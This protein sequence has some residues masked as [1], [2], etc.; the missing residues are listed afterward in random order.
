MISVNAAEKIIL[1]KV[2][3]FP[4][5]SVALDECLGMVLRE[6]IYADRDQP[7]FDKSLADGIAVS[8]KAWQRG[9]K[10]FLVEGI[11]PAGKKPLKIK[12]HDG[13]VE[14]MTG[15]VVP[16]GLDA[17]VPVERISVEGKI[18]TI[19][20]GWE[21][22]RGDHIRPQGSDAGKGDLFLKK[23]TVIGPQHIGILASAG[24]YKVKV[25]RSPAIAIISTG[26]ELVDVGKSVQFYQTRKSNSHALK[27]ILTKT[28]YSNAKMFHIKDNIKQLTVQSRK[29]LK[30]FDVVIL[31]G[32]V[33]MGKFD[34]VPL[35]LKDLK[36]KVLFHR[37]AQKPG[38]PF[39][40]GKT[41]DGKPVF[42]LPGNPVSTQMCACR[43]VLPYLKKASGVSKSLHAWASLAENFAVKTDLAYFLPVRLS[44]GQEG[45]LQAHPVANY[46]GSGDYAALADA[47]GFAEFPSGVN[48]F[49]RE[50][51]IKIFLW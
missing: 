6:D 44:S 35:V 27:A 26:D 28:G 46:S 1:E 9:I 10:S 36:V 34:Y 7:P 24:K 39:W 23:G 41:T 14:I 19:A 30:D 31:S 13:C 42:A 2:K 15:A 11:Q 51:T 22:R 4:V 33:S 3:L 47:D 50:S 29:V 45:K 16:K 8:S 37:V 21:A 32:G 43:Y 5:V 38:K 20:P 48:N 40:F 49:M 25:S 17:V 12:C 18:A